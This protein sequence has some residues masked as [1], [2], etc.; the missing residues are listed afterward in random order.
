MQNLSRA[1][2]LV[3]GIACLSISAHAALPVLWPPGPSSGAQKGGVSVGFA[4]QAT[5][6]DGA[7]DIA[8]MNV[9]FWNSAAGSGSSDQ[10]VCWM[11]Y[12][13]PD[14][15]LWVNQNMTGWV[16]APVGSGG[17]TLNGNLC[18]IDTSR[19]TVDTSTAGGYHFLTLVVPVTFAVNLGGYAQSQPDTL[20][21]YMRAVSNAGLDTGYQQVGTWTVTPGAN[22]P[23]FGMG[24]QPVFQAV[25][26]GS[27]AS[28]TVTVSG[29][30]GFSG[31]VSFNAVLVC[32]GGTSTQ[33]NAS[34]SP[35]TVTGSGST[36]MTITTTGSTPPAAYQVVVTG[37]SGSLSHQFGSELDVVNAPPSVTVSPNSGTGSSQ[38]FSIDISD[39]A[40]SADVQ[41]MNLLVNSSL[42]GSSAC[43]L[44][45]DKL[46][47][48]L[49]LAS[50]DASSWTS[51]AIGSS[52]SL[53][54]SQCTVPAAGFSINY[55]GGASG[56]DVVVTLPV[57]FS[58]TF[59]GAKTVFARA[60]NRAGLDSGYQAA[61]NWS[62]P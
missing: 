9:F 40:G 11:F 57:I 23:D 41:S 38:T 54:N 45:F 44:Y 61:G 49:W 7:N 20:T 48:L 59:S 30:N 21:T 32:C 19:A 4:F 24:I 10:M 55:S 6:T 5:D 27:S 17:S 14:N 42:S 39:Q 18:S 16:S 37:T 22:N 46:A 53:Q 3:S 31:P 47:G 12:S 1:C 29:T 8:G 15:T 50:D 2:A 43:W 62:V 34:F 58:S 13:H 33:A 25:T 60:V 28:Y 35:P 56:T 26:A 51:R 36:T 52:A